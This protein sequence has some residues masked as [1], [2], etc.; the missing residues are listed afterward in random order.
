M[1]GI[2]GYV[3]DVFT[4]Q[5]TVSDMTARLVHRG[6]DDSGV[7][8]LGNA[9]FGHRRLKVL[10]L[11]KNSA[12]PMLSE[13]GNFLLTFNGEIYNY[14]ALQEELRAEGV[15][16][17]SN[18][19]TEVVLRAF[20]HWGEACLHKFNGMFSIAI[21]NRVE[22]RLFLARDRIGEKSL[23]YTLG[24]G[25]LQFASEPAALKTKAAKGDVTGLVQFMF[26][27]YTVGGRTI[28]KEI[29]RL[30]PGFYLTVSLADL[31]ANRPI[32]EVRYWSLSDHFIK[33]SELT[34]LEAENEFLNTFWS[35]KGEN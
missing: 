32:E 25:G 4:S 13:C 19:D 20:M 26:L 35:K 1:C 34:Y 5:R 2:C 22:R 33:R 3:G 30:K 7:V 9:C 16:F 11:S 18:G 23:Y 24:R 15:S 28:Q 8:T 21:Y 6:P 12:Q 10:D 27:N 29:K 31:Q 14:R 17:R